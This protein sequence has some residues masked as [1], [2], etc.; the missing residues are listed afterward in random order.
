MANSTSIS[1]FKKNV[2]DAITHDDTI[3]YAFGADKVKYENGG[4]LIGTHILTYNKIPD[5][6]ETVSTYMT[7]MVHTK[8]FDSRYDRN[9]TFVIPRLEFYIYSHFK[10]MQMDRE[11]TKDNRC[12]YISMLIDNMFNGSSEYGGIGELKLSL[13]EEGAYNKDFLYRHMV[14]ETVDLNKSFCEYE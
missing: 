14:F 12:D 1:D 8:V 13:N 4:D 3:F 11:I 6:V 7:I 2:V 5:T 9:K 10:H